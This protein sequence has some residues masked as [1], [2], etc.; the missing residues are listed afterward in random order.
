MELIRG[1]T[2]RAIGDRY[3]IA[4]TWRR[5]GHLCAL[6]GRR[7][8]AISWMEQSMRLFD[9]IGATYWA[10]RAREQAQA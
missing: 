7:E 8:E 5:R 6:E 4:H 9:E 3:S 2:N 10:H 1:H